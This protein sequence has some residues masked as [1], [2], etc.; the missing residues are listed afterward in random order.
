MVY[1]RTGLQTGVPPSPIEQHARGFAIHSEVVTDG[2]GTIYNLYTDDGRGNG[3][4]V[5]ETTDRFWAFRIAQA[6]DT[7]TEQSS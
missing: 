4:Y 5:C 6:L 2:R 7:T 1:D 3:D